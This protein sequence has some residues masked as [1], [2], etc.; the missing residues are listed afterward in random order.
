MRLILI[1]SLFLSMALMSLAPAAVAQDDMRTEA[2]RFAAGASG[3]VIN[4]TIVGRESVAYRLGAE[5]GQ[6]MTISLNPT[7]NATYF[8]VFGSGQAPGGE[9]LAN[10]E[11]V[12][13]MVPDLNQFDA[14]LPT[15]GEYTVLVY[16]YRSAARRG[17]RSDFTLDVAIMGERSE[18]LQGD[19][20][21][22]L[23][24]G[25]DFFEVRTA[26]AGGQ[27][28][29]RNGPSTG[30]P[31][32]TVAR[33]GEILR[34][35][36][37]R[38]NEGRR[39]CR[40]ATTSGSAIEAWA[41][42]DFLFESSGTA[43]A[44][45]QL[46]DMVPVPSG[47]DALVPGTPYNATGMIS[48]V[49]NADAPMQDCAFGVIRTQAGSGNGS[50]TIDWPDGGSRVIFFEGGNPISFDQSQADQ[51]LQMT[52]TIADNGMIIVM[53]GEERFEIPD[54]VIWGG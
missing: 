13:P 3:A 32:A 24:G 8:T 16:L 36:G 49:R 27:I 46:P 48:C 6:R 1:P 4:D 5:A 39:W 33:N 11:M 28:N 45:T 14:V 40:V 51:G 10:S 37:C 43:G 54:S 30:S 17:E 15:S 22:G 12:G 25:P 26:S 20:A 7:N 19:F 52:S 34:N 42:G 35:L 9:G 23:E 50:V 2:V 53:I 31:V 29:L 21:D 18:I 44:V 47:G 41:A 38:M